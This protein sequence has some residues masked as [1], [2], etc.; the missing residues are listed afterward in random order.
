M[1]SSPAVSKI[2]GRFAAALLALAAPVAA[3][4]ARADDLQ[5][6]YNV[7]L[8]GLSLGT[9]GLTGTIDPTSYRV[10][11]T[12]KLTGVATIVSNAKGAATST[13]LFV[14]GR[15]AP[16]GFATTS[17]NS[18]TTR[19]IRIAMQ[20]GNVKASEIT[21][22]F[23]SPPDRI[24]IL[25]AQKHNVIDPLSAMI[26]PVP[27]R[28]N[29]VGPAAC[30]RVIPVFDGWTR[31]DISLSYVGMRDVSIKGYSGPVAVCGVRYTPVSGHRDRPVVRFMADN[32]K[33]E[34]WLAPVGNTHMAVP[35][36]ISVETMI[37]VVVIEASDYS[38][39]AKAAQR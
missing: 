26:M 9:A 29:V 11:A 3:R 8:I 36:Y 20:A 27:L 17:A 34:T 39:A 37:G 14:Q 16:N 15:V 22:P 2:A 28:E 23:E 1:I 38:V 4:S 6:R 7:K 24:P 33:M 31:F 21:P 25:E 13:G 35:V 18:Q 30:N 5:V 10:D 12:A 19:T 32:K